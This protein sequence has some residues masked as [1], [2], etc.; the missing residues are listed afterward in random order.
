MKIKIFVTGWAEDEY[1]ITDL[2]WFE[3][4][5][6]HDFN[7]EGH[8]GERYTFRFEVIDDAAPTQDMPRK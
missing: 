4:N 2:Y 3:E 6:V 1:E 8:W 7:G 5:G